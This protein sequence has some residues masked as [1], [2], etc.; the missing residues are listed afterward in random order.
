MFITYKGIE[1]SDGAVLGDENCLKNEKFSNV[2]L[3]SIYKVY[4][5]RW[6]GKGDNYRLFGMFLDLM[7]AEDYVESK[8]SR[9]S[10][11]V[12]EIESRVLFQN[13]TTFILL[14]FEEN[15]GEFKPFKSKKEIHISSRFSDIVDLL[16]SKSNWNDCVYACTM[17]EAAMGKSDRFV[18]FN[19]HDLKASNML[20]SDATYSPFSHEIGKEQVPL[21]WLPNGGTDRDES[22]NLKAFLWFQ[23]AI[24][25]AHQQFKYFRW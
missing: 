18:V 8:R 10:S 23:K 14:D 15:Y 7:H 16:E 22:K 5:R 17:Y 6:N 2:Q 9:G 20:D 19:F 25:N 24:L 13:A 11:W 4:R 3:A 12:I 21:E 1:C